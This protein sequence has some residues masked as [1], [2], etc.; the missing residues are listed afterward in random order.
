MPHYDYRC[1]DCGCEYEVFQRMS[2]PLLTECENC[3][4]PIQ[5]LLSCG[6]GLIFK[7]TGFYITDYKN[8]GKGKGSAS[9]D[10]G[11]TGNSSRNAEA[12]AE[13]AE[14]EKAETKNS[15]EKSASKSSAETK[16][17]K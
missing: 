4:G 11:S 10:A 7:G 2:D 5:R 16:P 9:S 12:K 8:K 17:S 1:D 14:S 15:S 13:K 3:G 6:T